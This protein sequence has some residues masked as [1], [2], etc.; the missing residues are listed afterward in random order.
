MFQYD[1]PKRKQKK[2]KFTGNTQNCQTPSIHATSIPLQL[3]RHF[4]S[5]SCFSPTDVQVSY[6]FKRSAQLNALSHTQRNRVYIAP[7]QECCPSYELGHIVPQK[8]GFPEES[9]HAQNSD[10]LQLYRGNEVYASES[11]SNLL[12][13][14]GKDAPDGGV[15]NEGV[16]SNT[17]I[18]ILYEVIAQKNDVPALVDNFRKTFNV[19]D[20]KRQR[21]DVALSVVSNQCTPSLPFRPSPETTKNPL[22]HIEEVAWGYKNP[23][24]S[25]SIPSIHPPYYNL[26]RRA[27]I[28]KMATSFADILSRNSH[29]LWH[30][31]ADSDIRFDKSNEEEQEEGT[32]IENQMSELA[33]ISANPNGTK[34]VTFGYIL[35]TP[36]IDYDTAL[37]KNNVYSHMSKNN[38]E[39]V[40]K[41]V[42]TAIDPF[43]DYLYEKEAE[44]RQHL[45]TV[46]DLNIQP[47]PSEPSTYYQTE[48]SADNIAVW[49]SCSAH[50]SPQISE[51]MGLYKSLILEHGGIHQ[52]LPTPLALQKT[53][54]GKRHTELIQTLLKDYVIDSTNKQIHLQFKATELFCCIKKLNQS[55]FNPDT[56]GLTTTTEEKQRKYNRFQTEAN[57]FLLLGS[58]YA[59]KITRI[60]NYE[61]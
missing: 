43:V 33:N 14:E 18:S 13:Y 27:S 34:M 22:V 55:Y 6:N 40:L 32:A 49:K 7:K 20:P 47:Y 59:K 25:K 45:Q 56:H 3:Q 1:S 29:S 15:P 41:A 19:T 58:E 26:R 44:F 52:F 4:E 60:I 9:S 8:Q 57:T 48:N 54:A 46:A 51:G 31:M 21:L 2:E 35:T 16:Y 39:R 37:N 53:S 30:R 36:D 50:S 42:K 38:K 12:Y 17:G 11:G 10:T 28:N 24:N 5:I 61:Y 23:S